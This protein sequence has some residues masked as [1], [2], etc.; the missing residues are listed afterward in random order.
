MFG[1]QWANRS[2]YSGGFGDRPGAHR[3]YY[4]TCYA[5][6]GLSVMNWV[7]DRHGECVERNQGINGQTKITIYKSGF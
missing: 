3:D 7:Y 2:G 6:S 1:A 4:H 5:L